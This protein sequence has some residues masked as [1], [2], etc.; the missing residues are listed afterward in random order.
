MDSLLKVGW[1]D[2]SWFK[3]SGRRSCKLPSVAP[4]RMRCRLWPKGKRCWAQQRFCCDL[5]FYSAKIDPMIFLWR[6][7]MPLSDKLQPIW[8]TPLFSM[9]ATHQRH[10]WV[11]NF[12]QAPGATFDFGGTRAGV[13][14]GLSMKLER[15]E[16]VSRNQHINQPTCWSLFEKDSKRIKSLQPKQQ[17]IVPQNHQIQNTQFVTLMCLIYIFQW[18][19]SATGFPHRV[20]LLASSFCASSLA[21]GFHVPSCSGFPNGGPWFWLE[22]RPGFEGFTGLKIQ[23]IGT[24]WYQIHPK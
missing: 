17:R 7:N 13:V 6:I 16:Q 22:V 18:R 20:R 5:G 14:F 19:E 12:P 4:A 21:R 3:K 23:V 8:K 11:V 15:T 2:L 10:F 24:S 9:T 1:Q